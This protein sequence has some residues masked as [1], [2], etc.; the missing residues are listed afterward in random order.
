MKEAVQSLLLRGYLLPD[1]L[2]KICTFKPQGGTN[3]PFWGTASFSQEFP[4]LCGQINDNEMLPVL[5]F[6]VHGVEIQKQKEAREGC[7]VPSS[8]AA[9]SPSCSWLEGS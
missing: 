7:K 9:P 4:I 2:R 8:L 5:S 1:H 6:G 3:K